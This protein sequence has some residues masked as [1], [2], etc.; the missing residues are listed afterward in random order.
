MK[1]LQNV[2]L[3]VALTSATAAVGQ[4]GNAT[5]AIAGIGTMSC[6]MHLE[7]RKDATRSL[8]LVTWA[9]GFLSGMNMASFSSGG[10]L[11]LIPDDHTIQAYLEK[12]CRDNPLK[13]PFMGAAELYN[14]LG[15]ADLKR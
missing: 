1:F 13:I 7:W 3:L 14:Q 10:P 5:A 15:L 4:S 2:F 6:G 11:R 8:V 12:F 9:Q